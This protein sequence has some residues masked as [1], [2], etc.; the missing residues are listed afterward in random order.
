M[1]S[2]PCRSS[3]DLE[4]LAARFTPA[5]EAGLNIH[6]QGELGAGKTT[7]ARG[8][9]R[10]LGHH[11]AVKSPTYTLVEPYRLAR[12]TVYHFDFYRFHDPAE[13]ES[14]GYRDYFAA[15]C[16]CLVEWPERA[17][18]LLPPADIEI[19]LQ[20]HPPGRQAQC[21]GRSERGRRLLN[22]LV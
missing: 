6:L 8:L 20:I 7:F 3:A 14:I 16:C 1:L 13:L 18:G 12:C 15:D 10:A 2:V 9:L 11:G 21:C 5:A 19:A 4:R 17:K 22:D